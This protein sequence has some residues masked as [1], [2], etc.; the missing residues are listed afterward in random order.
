[1]NAQRKTP[2]RAMV[3]AAG[4]GERMRPLTDA[5]P[6]PL[7]RVAGRPLIEYH[8]EG[9]AR[10]GI[11]DVVI[12]LSWLGEQIREHLGDGERFGMVLQYSPEGYPALETGGGIFRA[13]PLLGED[14]FLL[15][16]ADVY[17]PFDFSSLGLDEG[18]LAALVMVPNPAHHPRGDFVLEQGRVHTGDDRRLTFSGISVLHPDLFQGCSDGAFPL[19]PLLV[20]AM[21]KGRVAGKVHHGL[22]SDVGTPERL[23]QLEALLNRR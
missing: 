8:L 18:D 6:K 23:A 1:V 2:T 17:C 9:L 5:C 7:L 14:P 21:N 22:W 19:A 20:S 13:L 12:N 4:R 3:L 15:V 10:A 11:Q 16:N